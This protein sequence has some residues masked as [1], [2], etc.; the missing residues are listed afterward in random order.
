MLA[1]SSAG[2]GQN[3]AV[4]MGT[5]APFYL[6]AELFYRRTLYM[7]ACSSASNEQNNA[8]GRQNGSLFI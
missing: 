4:G 6:I 8:V 5:R 7:L 3:D 1:C 2:N